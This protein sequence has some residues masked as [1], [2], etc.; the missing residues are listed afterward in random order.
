[1]LFSRMKGPPNQCVC[2]L[3]DFGYFLICSLGVAFMM[4]RDK[5]NA[6]TLI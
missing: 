6:S 5:D 2:Q 4:N 3:L 1:M